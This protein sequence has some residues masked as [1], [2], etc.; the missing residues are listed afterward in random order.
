M[1]ENWIKHFTL[2]KDRFSLIFFPVT[3]LTH[4]NSAFFEVEDDTHIN[5]FTFALFDLTGY[6]RP[7]LSL[8][9]R[10]VEYECPC[11]QPRVSPF[12]LVTKCSRSPHPCTRVPWKRT[13]CFCK[14]TGTILFGV[15]VWKKIPQDKDD[16][17]SWKWSL[18]AGA[19]TPESTEEGETQGDG[20]NQSP[21]ILQFPVNM[22]SWLCL[23]FVKIWW[24][25]LHKQGNW[26]IVENICLGPLA[27]W[28]NVLVCLP[29]YISRP[30]RSCG[31]LVW[32]QTTQ[33][34]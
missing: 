17:T 26:V 28:R 14:E 10:L 29:L 15:H 30:W 24:Q 12:V 20:R 19:L 18:R 8:W 23:V 16:L 22:L 1:N 2:L 5:L 3:V 7:L 32:P 25:R 6:E 21:S 33:F 13:L 9:G 31:R 27:P 4:G 34:S 11:V